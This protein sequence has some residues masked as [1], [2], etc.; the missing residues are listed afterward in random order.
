MYHM[1]MYSIL[2]GYLHNNLMKGFILFFLF[3]LIM[4]SYIYKAR[5]LTGAQ[6]KRKYSGTVT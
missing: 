5:F 3:F 4:I 2:K 1:F 6:Y